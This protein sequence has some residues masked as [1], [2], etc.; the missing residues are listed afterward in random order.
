MRKRRSRRG[1][2]KNVLAPA[3]TTAGTTAF[4][5]AR[6]MG[7]LGRAD[8]AEKRRGVGRK[9]GIFFFFLG[10]LEREVGWVII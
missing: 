6:V 9:D 8:A 10:L 1:N 5:A 2:K 3:T 4:G 7:V